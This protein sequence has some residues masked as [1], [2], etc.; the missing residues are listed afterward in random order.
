MII[1]QWLIEL[2]NVVL[3]LLP[4]VIW[5]VVCLFGIHWQRMWTVLRE[6]AWIPLA[7]LFVLV[8]LLW[9]Q[10]APRELSVYGY[11]SL[12]NFWWQLGAVCLVAA[13]GFFAGWLQ[14]QYGW[15]P[16]E[17]AVEPPEPAH[18]HAHHHGNDHHDIA[19]QD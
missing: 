6:G 8:A 15:F 11:F 4:M 10:C 13:V 12:A 2:G 9:S 5:F 3:A 17:V 7:L 16:Q 19:A 18:G 1:P 14:Q